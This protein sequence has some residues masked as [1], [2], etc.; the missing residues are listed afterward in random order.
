MKTFKSILKKALI[1]IMVMTLVL[2]SFAG[3][4]KSVSAHRRGVTHS[5]KHV[6]RRRANG[7]AKKSHR[8]RRVTRRRV[9]RRK[10]PRRRKVPVRRRKAVR[11][12]KRRAPVRKKRSAPKKRRGVRKKRA[13]K[14]R[15]APRRKK[16]AK[17]RKATPKKKRAAKKRK[18]ASKKKAATKHKASKKKKATKKRTKKRQVSHAKKSI[19]KR[20]PAAKKKKASGSAL[21]ATISRKTGI[22]KSLLS[23]VGDFV[24]YN[25]LYTMFTG[26]D[27]ATGKPRSRWI[28]AAWT[29]FNFIPISKVEK[30]AKVA[31]ILVTARK[32]EKVAKDVRVGHLATR[33]IT[34]R[35]GET[36]AKKAAQKRA[37]QLVKQR[38]KVKPVKVKRTKTPGRRVMSKKAYKQ[39]YGK[40]VTKKQKQFN[41]KKSAQ[42]ARKQSYGRSKGVK[43]GK[44]TKSAKSAKKVKKQTHHV[45]P[46]AKAPLKNGPYIRNGKPYGRPTLSGKKKLQFEKAVYKK[47]VRKD[48]TIRDYNTKEII[49]WKPGE[50]RKGKVDFGHVSGQSYREIFEAYKNRKITLKQLKEIQFNPKNY[51]LELPSNNRSHKYE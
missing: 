50:P 37:E 26:K 44:A 12:V 30:I 6:V 2:T 5:R 7:H 13:A 25:D 27:A 49:D 9:V 22:S 21:I 51:R 1:V 41:K 40:K 14:K 48:N 15:Q 19:K 33:A 10:A 3:S 18:A 28:G 36:A 11:H 20:Q 42:K 45:K 23:M 32:G 34:K 47:Y 16:A 24:G 39:K 4:A 43:K 35:T 38:K 17:K 8:A 29:A 46:K 31:K